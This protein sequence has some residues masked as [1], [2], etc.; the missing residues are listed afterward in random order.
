VLSLPLDHRVL[1]DVTCPTTWFQGN[2]VAVNNGGS[3]LTGPA[4]RMLAAPWL[5]TLFKQG[6]H[7]DWTVAGDV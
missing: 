3:S 5:S 4:P 7:A 2:E 1:S 6:T